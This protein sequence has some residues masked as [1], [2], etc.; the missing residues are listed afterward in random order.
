MGSKYNADDGMIADINVTPLVDVVLVL[1]IIFMVTAPIIYHS[2]IK[3]ELPSAQTGEQ[4]QKTQFQF[5]ITKDNQVYWEEEKIEWGQIEKKL[6]DLGANVKDKTAIIS[7]DQE[8]SHGTVV[9]LM[10]VLRKAGLMKFGLNVEGAPI[11]KK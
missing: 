6:N 2:A 10:D 1:L 4:T 8:S 5:S 3:V 9:K 11:N 7:A